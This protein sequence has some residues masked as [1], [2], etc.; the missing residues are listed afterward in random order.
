MSKRFPDTTGWLYVASWKP[1]AQSVSECTTNKHGPDP[2]AKC[3][4]PFKYH[5]MIWYDCLRTKTPT[6][7]N[8]LCMELYNKMNRTKL[9]DKHY[10]R[11]RRNIENQAYEF[12]PGP[13]IPHDLSMQ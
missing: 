2:F 4:F 12:R 6:A 1:R 9:L 10:E 7:D 11:V 3:K 5:G 8:K 13:Q